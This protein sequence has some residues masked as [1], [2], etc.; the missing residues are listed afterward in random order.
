MKKREAFR[1]LNGRDRD[2]IQALYVWGHSQKEI[3]DILEVNPG[4]ISRELRRYDKKTWRY[5]AI[6]AEE[7]AR[8]KREQSKRPG[9]K[10]EACPELKRHII[11][12]LKRLRS[13]DEIAGRLKKKGITPRVGKNAI[14]EWLYSDYGKPYCHYLCTKRTKK[15]GQ[16]RLGTKV[17]IPNRI[18]LRL[19]P[20]AP[21]LVHAEGDL[22]VTPTRLHVKTCGLLVVVP[23]AHLLKGNII[24]NKTSAVVVPAM[25]K[26]TA[27][28]TLDT[29]TFDNGI[30]N[31][32]HE[33]FGVDA[34]FCDKASPWQKPYVESSIGLVRR[35]FLPKGTNLFDVPDE[36]FQS[37][38]HLLNHKYRKSLGYRSAYEVALERGIIEK[39][40]RISLT[41]AIAFR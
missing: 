24:P 31:I 29:C 37:Q 11:K 14:Y 17:L 38:L 18:P 8:A 30:E 25:Q 6:R 13:P 32:H 1:H 28:L 26:I 22:F 15:R 4:T 34:Y 12:E 33:E 21:E 7:D 35:W 23:E 19:R 20:D 3:A 5:R 9:V 41:K 40:P 39:V 16:R 36:V 27:R 10:I 2:R